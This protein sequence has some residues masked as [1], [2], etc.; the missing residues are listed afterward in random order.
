VA[1]GATTK[2]IAKAIGVSFHTVKT[3]L[4]RIFVKLNVQ[5]GAHAVARA[6]GR[7]LLPERR[8]ARGGP[9]SLPL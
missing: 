4:E 5:D 3:H 2:Q 8:K 1:H 7:G 6:M 9:R